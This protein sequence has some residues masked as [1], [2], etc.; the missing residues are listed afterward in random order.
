MSFLRLY[1]RVLALLR[2]VVILAVVLALANVALAFAQFAEPLLFGKVVDRLASAQ[3]R[4]AAP[5]WDDIGPWVALWAGF[6]LFS[7]VASVLV[8]LY[9]DRLAHRRR[10]AAMADYFEHVMHLPLR[11]HAQAHSG[12]LFKVMIEGTNAMFSV[13]LSFFREHCAGFV[14]LFVL[15]PMTLFV[16]FRL[17]GILIALVVVFALAM[18]SS[19][20]KPPLCRAGDRHRHQSGR[21]GFGRARQSPG[22]PE[23][24][25][26]RGRGAQ[27]ARDQRT[28]ARG[29]VSG[30]DLVGDRLGRDARQFD[31]VAAR[32]LPRRHLARHSRRDDDRADRRLHEP[33]DRC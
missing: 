26:R 20:A 33:R 28:S 8:S 3:S 21:A 27:P 22:H 9:A 32:D 14:A 1:A 16:N 17:G 25:P 24:H 10:L 30:A 4:N 5:Q 12:R 31:A 2:P 6:G 13:W 7:I 18:N 29:A 15:L 11:F 23:L 19:S